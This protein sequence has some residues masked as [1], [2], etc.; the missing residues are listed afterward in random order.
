MHKCKAEIYCGEKCAVK[1]PDESSLCNHHKDMFA[2]DSTI[3]T[4]PKKKWTVEQMQ[5]HIRTVMIPRQIEREKTAS[6]LLSNVRTTLL[7][8]LVIAGDNTSITH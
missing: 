8:K 5:A 3:A 6:T 7:P 2:G 4:T 1:I